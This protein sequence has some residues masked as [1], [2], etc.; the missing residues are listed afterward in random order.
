[1]SVQSNLEAGCVAAI[2]RLLRSSNSVYVLTTRH[3]TCTFK[4]FP[5][6]R[7]VWTFHLIYGLLLIWVYKPDDMSIGSA[8]I[9]QLMVVPKH[10]GTQRDHAVARNRIYPVRGNVA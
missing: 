6:R 8:V 2:R 9:A 5:S 3:M 4:T 1:M 7:I 10:A